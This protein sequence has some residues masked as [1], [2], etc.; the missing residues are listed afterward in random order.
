MQLS[1]VGT[2]QQIE[3]DAVTFPDFWQLYP[4]RV[5]KKDA[6]RAWDRLKPDQQMQACV[7][8]MDWRTIW[9]QRGELQYVPNAAKW[10]NGERFEDEFPADFTRSQIK[11]ASHQPFKQDEPTERA[12]MPDR[13]REMLKGMRR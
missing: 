10:L 5:A 9:L 11:P 2:E 7:A 6:M 4:K 12:P 3:T 8:L 1:I 13:L